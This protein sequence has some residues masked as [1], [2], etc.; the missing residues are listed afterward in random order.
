V[1]LV[2]RRLLFAL[3]GLSTAVAFLADFAGTAAA[4]P[5]SSPAP[6]CGPSAYAYAGLYSNAPAPG[7]EANVTALAIAQVPYGH[8]AGWIGVGGPNAGPGG[9]A[10]WLQTGL[11]TLAG[12]RSQLY[13]EITQ[14]GLLPRYLT[15]ASGIAPGTTYRLAVVRV[16]DRPNTWQVI[17]DGQPATDSVSL[18]ASSGFAPMAMSESWNGGRPDCNGFSY[19]FNQLRIANSHGGWVPLT[20]T[21]TLA[22]S[23]YQVIDRTKAGFTALSA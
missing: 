13:A 18:P 5:M 22:D 15:L 19:R 6:S 3:A 17:V 10:E 4:V 23:G 21:S 16:D 14:P 12:D 7:I 9:Q 1:V 11:V 8:V 20:N 2:S